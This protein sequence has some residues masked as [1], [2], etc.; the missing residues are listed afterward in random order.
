MRAT[1]PRARRG[2]S[3]PTASPCSR[4]GASRTHPGSSR[5]R[6]S[7]ASGRGLSTSSLRAVSSAHRP[8]P[9]PRECRLPAARPEP[10]RLDVGAEPG[11][12]G[13]AS[14]LSSAGYERVDR[15][16]D[17]G[18]FAVRGGIVDV[19]P[20][21]GREPLRV[22]L[23]GDEIEQVRAF[24]PFTQRALHTITEARVYPAAERRRESID[25]E[26][27]H[28]W[29][30]E[31]ESEGGGPP[32][33]IDLV[34][35]IDRAPDFVWQP[36]DVRAV[37]DEEGLDAGRARRRHRARP[38]PARAG[39]PVRGSTAGDRGPRPGRGRE[40]AGRIRPLRQPRRRHVP[41]PRRGAAPGRPAAEGR[42]HDPRGRRSP[43][44]RG[45]R[46]VRRLAGAARVRLA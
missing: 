23:F 41:A 10:V 7:S 4:A 20:S 32:I 40:R 33:P 43:A 42:E 36:D 29:E 39:I 16:D 34:P 1:P 21:T 27:P 28:G 6:T 18:Q 24:S 14:A 31:T 38:L 37:W 26:V 30:R 13:L 22:E 8:P 12:D 35:P 25:P 19:F 11:L 2:S 5:R 45:K 46:A 9:W 15:V 44:A 17:R 3:V